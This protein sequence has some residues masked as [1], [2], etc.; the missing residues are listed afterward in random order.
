MKVISDREFDE[1]LKSGWDQI[2]HEGY[3]GFMNYGP[4]LVAV[5]TIKGEFTA[6]FTYPADGHILD[7]KVLN[8]INQYDPESQ[9]I[10]QY[11]SGPGLVKTITLEMGESQDSPKSIWDKHNTIIENN[12]LMND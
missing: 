6:M 12:G 5:A 1:I 2:C 9:V 11:A 8:M 3:G 4:G 7:A 10:V